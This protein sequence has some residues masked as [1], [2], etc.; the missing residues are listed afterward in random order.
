M[1]KKKKKKKKTEGN[2]LF[3]WGALQAP[4]ACYKN[5]LK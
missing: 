3:F 5:K 4:G 2:Q 1:K